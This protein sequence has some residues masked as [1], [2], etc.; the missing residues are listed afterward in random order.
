MI[1]LFFS[2]PNK[3]VT[4]ND[5]QSLLKRKQPILKKSEIL[6]QQ[7]V[8]SSQT[9]I[10][11]KINVKNPKQK[12]H[13]S[14]QTNHIV[15]QKQQSTYLS[16][17]LNGMVVLGIVYHHVNIKIIKLCLIIPLCQLFINNNL[18]HIILNFPRLHCILYFE[19][20]MPFRLY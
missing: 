19:T 3:Y 12:L 17:C 20:I 5:N 1:D 8:S 14:S 7:F 11:Q 9:N 15:N 4:W 16:Q 18:Q 10:V 6:F 13:I 2:R